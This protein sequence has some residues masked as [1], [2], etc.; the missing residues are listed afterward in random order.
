[1]DTLINNSWAIPR[2]SPLL[3]FTLIKLWDRRERNHI[4][5]AAYREI[6]G[7]RVR[8]NDGGGGLWRIRLR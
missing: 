2:R 1:M 3:Q 5:W 7:G 8:S 6:G 4:T